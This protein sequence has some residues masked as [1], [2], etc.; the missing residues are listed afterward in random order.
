MTFSIN[1]N[2]FDYCL[3][4]MIK[5]KKVIFLLIQVVVTVSLGLWI[6]L[7][8]HYAYTRP[9]KP[10]PDMERIY[11]LHVHR[12]TVYLTKQEDSQ[13]NWIFLTAMTST[14]IQMFYLTFIIRNNQNK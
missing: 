11:P 4:A 10:Q 13:L 7:D 14:A 6:Y 2:W 8:Y 3:R 9:K 5:H 12:T 1:I